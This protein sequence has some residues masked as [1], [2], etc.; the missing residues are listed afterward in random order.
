MIKVFVQ[1]QD[2]TSRD[3]KKWNRQGVIVT[4]GKHDQY[5][6]RI[7]GTGRLTV[8]NRRFLRRY[9]L[10]SP[11]VEEEEELPRIKSRDRR[12]QNKM[13][14]FSDTSTR[15]QPATTPYED[16]RSSESKISIPSRTVSN[17]SHLDT[18]MTPV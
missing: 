7:N 8:R 5:L 13:V 15:Q 3:Y 18:E 11:V 1:K 10:R 6:V 4:A 16:R 12:Q 9:E 2:A 17:K 14:R